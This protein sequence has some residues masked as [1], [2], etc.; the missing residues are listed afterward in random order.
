[1]LGHAE[2]LLAAMRHLIDSLSKR[3][4]SVVWRRLLTDVDALEQQTLRSPGVGRR[5]R[6]G[7][8]EKATLPSEMLSGCNFHPYEHK[9]NLGLAGKIGFLDDQYH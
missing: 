3:G 5:D 6:T 9:I 1:V 7:Q 8:E 4:L 2:T